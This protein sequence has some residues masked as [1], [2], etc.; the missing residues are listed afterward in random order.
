M[1][2]V[3]AGLLGWAAAALCCWTQTAASDP[4]LA[5]G[6][7]EL[8][9]DV[10]LLADEGVVRTP[11]TSWPLSWADLVRDLDAVRSVDLRTPSLQDAYDRLR[12]EAR[13]NTRVDVVNRHV[14]LQAAEKP[15][16]MRGFADAPREELGFGGGVDWIGERFATRL[17]VSRVFDPEDGKVVRFDGSYVGMVVGNV[18]ISAGYM[19]KWWGPAWSG[20]LILSSNA[21]PV[22]SITIERNL[23]TPFEAPILRRLGAW[24]AS[25][26]AGRLER[27]R[28]DYPHAHFM[29]LRLTF[30]PMAHLEIGL[31]RTAQL[32]G[33]GRR[34]TGRTYW[35]MIS[36][37]DN[38]Q[39]LADQPG[40]QLAGMDFRWVPA[41]RVPVAIY[42]QAIGEDEAGFLPAKY[43]GLGG[44]ESWGRVRGW[45]VRGYAEYARTACNFSRREPLLGCAY[46]SSIY[47]AGY[48]Y[49]DRAI[50]HAM[51]RDGKGWTVGGIAQKDR[52]AV[53]GRAYSATLNQL[54]AGDAHS[55]APRGGRLRGFELSTHVGSKLGRFS[56][57]VGYD[58]VSGT[59]VRLERGG[60]V[61]VEW[62]NVV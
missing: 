14:K 40:N 2:R 58:H 24:R 6:D 23:S 57:G 52:V 29:A 34:C 4:W 50:A 5:P 56:L 25:F 47:T 45:T 41:R 54:G 30:K 38:D 16:R 39:A 43:L 1:R 36:G 11:V 60:K 3:P 13:R 27:D 8:R 28:S 46:E 48:R 33:D 42:A 7:V 61:F 12:R 22:P 59:A 18:M 44:L 19:E 53:A 17:Q 62:R 15:I 51:D 55:L 9:S 31:S 37:R 21:R 10:Q 35:N 49:R 20:S 26:Q 32:C